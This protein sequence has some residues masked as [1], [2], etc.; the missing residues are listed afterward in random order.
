[1]HLQSPSGQHEYFAY[2][3][4]TAPRASGAAPAAPTFADTLVIARPHVEHENPADADGV[5]TFGRVA[6]KFSRQ[7][8]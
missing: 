4:S 3:C 1:M 2:W 7:K 8:V 6:Q 5:P